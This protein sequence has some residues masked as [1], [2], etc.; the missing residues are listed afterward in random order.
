MDSYEREILNT[1]CNEIG[2]EPASIGEF[3]IEK[4]IKNTVLKLGHLNSKDLLKDISVSKNTLQILIEEIKVPETWFN[5]DTQAIIFLQNYIKD[6]YL[7]YPAKLPLN[8]LSAPCASGEEV[9]TI[10]IALLEI[11][12]CKDDF[13]IIGSDISKECLSKAEKGVY[14][15][16]SMRSLSDEYICNYFDKF[17]YQY[18]LKDNIK[19][20]NIKFINANLI[21][22]LKNEISGNF[23]LI[24]SKNLLIY[25]NDDSRKKLLNNLNI[26]LKD[27]GV[28]FAGIS[29]INYLTRNGFEQV[30][31]SMSFAC[32]KKLSIPLPK[33]LSK[34]TPLISKSFSFSTKNNK[35]T[36]HNEHSRLVQSEEVI[37]DIDTIRQLIEKENYNDALKLCNSILS[38]NGLNDKVLFWKGMIFYLQADYSSSK[39]AFTKALY[40]DS[41]CY[42]ALIYLSLIENQQGNLE[43]SALYKQRAAKVFELGK[44]ING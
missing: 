31:H 13:K 39:D 32:K 22:D 43:K 42:D 26:W 8:I 4:S 34:S 20:C 23:D 16:S 2:L 25:L 10:A 27:D 7:N 18:Y 11:G 3:S 6:N 44:T 29:E 37:S 1:I 30:N 28:L 21:K 12:L 36:I 38:K 41:N 35:P 15:K 19:N 33:K 40:L 17:D 9:Y 14:T 24:F 5:R